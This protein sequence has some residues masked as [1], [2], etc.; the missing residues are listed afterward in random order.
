MDKATPIPVDESTVQDASSPE[1]VPRGDP[2]PALSTKD[3]PVE[4]RRSLLSARVPDISVRALRPMA[5]AVHPQALKRLDEVLLGRY[6]VSGTEGSLSPKRALEHLVHEGGLER[7]E[8]TEQALLLDAVAE[9]PHDV[10]VSK[11]ALALLMSGALTEL[12]PATRRLTCEL[13]K[14]LGPNEQVSLARL[15]VRRLGSGTALSDEDSCGEPLVHHFLRIIRR[16]AQLGAQALAVLGQP[17]DLP[18]EEGPQSIP[19]GLEH[20]LAHAWPA[21]HARLLE[22]LT[23]P[24]GR[25]KLSGGI[26]LVNQDRM[27]NGCLRQL[28]EHLPPTLGQGARKRS[29]FA[30]GGSS[31][32]ATLFAMAVSQLF[33][34]RFLILSDTPSILL[35]LREPLGRLPSFVTVQTTTRER[36]FVVE[37]LDSQGVSVRTPR[38]RSSS[39]I[40]DIRFDPPRRVLNDEEGLDQIPLDIFLERVGVAWIP[41]AGK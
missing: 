41:Q 39:G 12:S 24:E 27:T 21:E 1:A 3:V 28:F 26:H 29:F 4:I 2:I 14:N 20:A 18:F 19:I 6:E 23:G 34:R 13:F 16:D 33:G 5:A 9:T 38:G 30:P 35:H 11:A 7:L 17:A 10:S 36:L 15:A 31:I 32:D 25:A 22:A 37:S 8:P 40:R